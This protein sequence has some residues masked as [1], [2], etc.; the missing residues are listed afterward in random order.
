MNEI[1]I[2]DYPELRLIAWTF[3]EDTLLTEEEIFGIY[4][5]NWDYVQTDKICAEEQNF[6]DRLTVKYGNGIM[7]V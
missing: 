7:N 5:R 4:E 1:R 3:T 6:I 2:G